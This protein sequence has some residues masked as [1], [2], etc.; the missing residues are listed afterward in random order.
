MF[1]TDSFLFLSFLFLS[2]EM[3]QPPKHVEGLARERKADIA[4]QEDGRISGKLLVTIT[5][6]Y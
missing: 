2:S 6:D 1:R 4:L 5:G 3:S